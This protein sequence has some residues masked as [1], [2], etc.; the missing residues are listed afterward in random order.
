MCGDWFNQ[1]LDPHYQKNYENE[2]FKKIAGLK[3]QKLV[4]V[5]KTT[6]IMLY[7]FFASIFKKNSEQDTYIWE[8][9]PKNTAD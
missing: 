5:N 8:K 1:V 3:Y 6:Q 2:D 7:L 4:F 9:I